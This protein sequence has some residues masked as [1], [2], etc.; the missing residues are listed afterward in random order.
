[1]LE[2]EG[3]DVVGE[4]GSAR[5]ADHRIVDR[6]THVAVLG[7]LPDGTSIEVCRDARSVGPGLKCLIL[8]SY[9]DDEALCA[10]VLAG[11]AGYVLRQLRSHE[12]VDTILRAAAGEPLLPHEE[13]ARAK[14]GLVKAPITPGL[15][16]LTDKEEAVLALI[17]EGRT[18]RQISEALILDEATVRQLVS[19]L[20]AK[21]GF[22]SRH[23]TAPA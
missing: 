3:L 4:S 18:N 23:P 15:D 16:E 8:T 22:R 11:A 10:V 6:G 2:Q 9:D 20:L 13:L 7:R 12:I 21:L 5:E 1:L 14:T 17:A 19:A